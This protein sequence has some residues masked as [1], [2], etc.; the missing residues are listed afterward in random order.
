DKLLARAAREARRHD[1]ELGPETLQNLNALGVLDPSHMMA[2][3]ND[4]GNAP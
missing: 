4:G 3:E 1:L 2:S